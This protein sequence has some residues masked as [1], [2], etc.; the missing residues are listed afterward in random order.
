M[1]F[2]NRYSCPDHDGTGIALRQRWSLLSKPRQL[3][4]RKSS[5]ELLG[6]YLNGRKIA[7]YGDSVR[8]LMVSMIK[9]RLSELKSPVSLSDLLVYTTEKGR[10]LVDADLAQDLAKLPRNTVLVYNMGLHDK[11]GTEEER[12]DYARRV[13]AV[14]D[15]LSNASSDHGHVAIWLETT[16]QHFKSVTGGYHSAHLEESGLNVSSADAGYTAFVKEGKAP[17]YP[18]V[19]ADAH[20]TDFHCDTLRE[21]MRNRIVVDVIHARRARVHVAPFAAITERLWD[22][23]VGGRDC[24]HFCYN[25]MLTEAF[26]YLILRIV[27]LEDAGASIAEIGD[28]DRSSSSRRSRTPRANSTTRN[29]ATSASATPATR[30]ATPLSSTTRR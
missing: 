26:A 23:H 8:G 2:G 20:T 4:S 7:Y 13:G 14:V 12:Q 27:A 29:T 25:P 3:S 19:P 6:E 11:V 10:Q 1:G 5:L 21:R 30:A 9:R 17:N 15:Q 22:G 24:T 16:A 18:C 28:W